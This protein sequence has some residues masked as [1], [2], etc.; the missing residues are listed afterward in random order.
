MSRTLI[1]ALLALAAIA[2]PYRS[3]A[4]EDDPRETS[5][6]SPVIQAVEAPEVVTPESVVE[7]RPV[8]L[9][10]QPDEVELDGEVE[11]VRERYPNRSVKI[12]REVIRDA[13][14]NYVNHGVWRMWDR[15]GN[16]IANGEF[17]QGKRHGEWT[18]WFMRGEAK[19][20][21]EAPF[22]E[23]EE[24]FKSTATFD[25]G[26]LHGKWTISDA[27]QRRVTDWEFAHGKRHGTWTYWHVSG[28]KIR[29]VEFE[30]GL[31]HGRLREWKPNGEVVRDDRFVQGRR[32]GTRVEYHANQ[33]KKSEG[34][35][36]YAQMVADGADDWWN[37]KVGSFIKSG[38]DQKHGDWKEWYP[39]GQIRLHGV[40]EFDRPKTNTPWTWWYPNGQKA[41]EGQFVDGEKVGKWTWWHENG[42]KS[43]EGH[44]DVGQPNQEWIWWNADG[45]V[46]KRADFTTNSPEAI[47]EAAPTL[48]EPAG[49]DIESDDSPATIRVAAPITEP[50]NQ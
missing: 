13:D 7:D 29:E 43:V 44:F 6:R 34:S 45:I 32:A 30:D 38:D 50:K 37:L 5:R 26:E 42:L 19:L 20:L 12:E 15:Q 27:K 17:R 1:A 36:L 28:A 40:Y 33:Q 16:M 41:V 14:D 10:N 9:A 25:D 18:A 21:T 31:C 24:P 48:I 22:S 49:E 35:V 11:V 8:D 3:S 2:F 46:A 23:F 47:A 4:D 39:N